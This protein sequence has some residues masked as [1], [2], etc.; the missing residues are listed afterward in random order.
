M[1]QN[2][3][4]RIRITWGASFANTL[5]VAYP[6]DD[7][8]TYSTYREGSEFAESYAGI[9]DAWITGTNY[10]LSGQIRWIPTSN[11]STPLATGWDGATGV[12]AF[13]EWARQQNQFRFFPDAAS[14]TFIL[15]YLLEPLDGQ[16]EL[17]ADGTRSIRLKIS[18]TTTPY[19]NY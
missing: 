9:R 2:F 4:K 12:R 5:N 3:Q 16:H 8:R 11:T 7:W 14:G 18:N 15:S 6:L 19:D 10:I 1:G 13:L 17:E